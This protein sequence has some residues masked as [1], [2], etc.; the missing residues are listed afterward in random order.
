MHQL[1]VENICEFYN[2]SHSH[3]MYS[4]SIRKG[5]GMENRKLIFLDGTTRGVTK[6]KQNPFGIENVQAD[7]K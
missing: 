1:L 2:H 3:G 7:T 4:L 5:I 6:Y